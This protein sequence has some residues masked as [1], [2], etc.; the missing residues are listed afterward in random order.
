MTSFVVPVTGLS[1]GS[2]EQLLEDRVGAV[3]G[4]TSVDAD[5][6][7]GTV[8]VAGDDVDRGRVEQ[9]VIETGYG[10]GE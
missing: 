2:C 9:V 7:A 6:V 10:V 5:H 1:C 3:E 4:V 8:R